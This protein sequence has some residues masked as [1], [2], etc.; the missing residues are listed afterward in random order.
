M[1]ILSYRIKRLDFYVFSDFNEWKTPVFKITSFTTYE[2]NKSI[3]FNFG[4]LAWEI[5]VKWAMRIRTK[6]L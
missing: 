5:G 4:L 1:K 2:G 3:Y 6:T